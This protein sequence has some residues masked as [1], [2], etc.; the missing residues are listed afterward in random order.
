[1]T[2]CR[3]LDKLDPTFR[4]KV[5][6]LLER[7]I[8]AGWKPLV[9]ETY[10]SPERG[11]EL[12]KRGVSKNG[13]LSMHTLCLAVDIVDGDRYNVTKNKDVPESYW[14]APA[15]FWA[16]LEDFAIDLGLT[17]IFKQG[18][19]HVA[20]D[21]DSESWDK[22]HVQAIAISEQNKVRA[23]TPAERATFVLDAAT[24]RDL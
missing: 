18:T 3:D 19:K 8:A 5:D 9:W 14:V 24:P 2:V 13:A 21:G 11:A 20:G 4:A 6:I 16:D 15:K 23:M 17:R 7:M 22:P 1:M 12:Q 10:R